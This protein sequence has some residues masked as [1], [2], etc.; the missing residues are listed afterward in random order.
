MSISETPSSHEFVGRDHHFVGQL[1]YV[2]DSVIVES[3]DVK[4]YRDRRISVESVRL[5]VPAD[6]KVRRDAN[7]EITV[8]IIKSAQHALRHVLGSVDGFIGVVVDRV[9]HALDQHLTDPSHLLR[10]RVY[11]EEILDPVP[12]SADP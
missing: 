12:D 11:S 2:F 6:R 7:I 1:T 9:S 3:R 10:R 5:P 8:E 4:I